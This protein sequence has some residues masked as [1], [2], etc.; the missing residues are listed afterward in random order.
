MKKMGLIA[1]TALALMLGGCA[2]Q[3]AVA[4]SETPVTAAP[5][6]AP[7]TQA[8][9]EVTE[10]ASPYGDYTQDEFFVKSVQAFW[11]G[12]VPSDA[13]LIGAGVEAC[14]QLKAG[15][16]RDAVVAVQGDGEDAAFNN[17][18]V[19]ISAIQAYCPEYDS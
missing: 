5:T 3:T 4:G 17:K 1:V 10:T 18:R 16:A 11:R 9:A 7:I 15:A 6:A 8:P 14:S 13:E 19:T 12:T 2:G